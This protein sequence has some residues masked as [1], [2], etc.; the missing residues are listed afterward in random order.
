ML[1]PAVNEDE[2]SRTRT[3]A[4]AE[5]ATRIGGDEGCGSR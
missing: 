4:P 3:A 2:S 5:G 1:P